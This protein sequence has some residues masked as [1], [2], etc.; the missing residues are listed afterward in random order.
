VGVLQLFDCVCGVAQPIIGEC[1]NALGV[2]YHP[3]H[4]CCEICKTT[5]EGAFFEHE[6]GIYCEQHYYKVGAHSF[7]SFLFLSS[8]SF[9]FKMLDVGSAV[10]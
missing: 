2:G 5:L 1:V 4:F 6:G 7:I 9:I 3:E 10:S 8:Y